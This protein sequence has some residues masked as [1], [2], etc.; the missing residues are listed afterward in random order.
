MIPACDNSL[1]EMHK[2]RFQP[3]ESYDR[4]HGTLVGVTSE[5]ISLKGQIKVKFT[6][7]ASEF[8]HVCPVCPEQPDF[9]EKMSGILGQ[10]VL[11]TR[12]VERLFAYSVISSNGQ[13]V[14]IT[15][16]STFT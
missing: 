3:G 4:P 7:G 11:G 1:L 14:S 12:G 2:R 6:L 13:E 15:R 8:E 9:Q 16:Y 5:Q 10:D